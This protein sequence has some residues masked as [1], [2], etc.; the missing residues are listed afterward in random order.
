MYGNNKCS[1][2]PGESWIGLDALHRLTSAGSWSLHVILTD[3]DDKSYTA[4]YD[5]FKV[6]RECEV[7]AVQ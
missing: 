7:S 3:W 1:F 4:V 2:T 6:S 5:R